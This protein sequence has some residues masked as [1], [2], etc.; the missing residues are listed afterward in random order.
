[1]SLLCSHIWQLCNDLCDYGYIHR[2][3]SYWAWVLNYKT[4][5]LKSTVTVL[6]CKYKLSLIITNN[7]VC[8]YKCTVYMLFNWSK[9]FEHWCLTLGSC[10]CLKC[11]T[12][13]ICLAYDI[14]D[15][16]TNKHAL[17]CT[18]NL[19]FLFFFKDLQRN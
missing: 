9:L 3:T 19:Y 16:K 14:Q 6:R 4:E 11:H 13:F 5:F 2:P 17:S 12:R 8:S 7:T 15:E 10:L 18:E 1:M